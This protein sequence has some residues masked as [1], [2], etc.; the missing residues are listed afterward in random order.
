MGCNSCSNITLPGSAGASGT[1]GGEGIRGPQGLTGPQGPSVSVIEIDTDA[2]N[3]NTSAYPASGSPNKRVVIPANTWQ[4]IDDLVELEMMFQFRSKYGPSTAY[5]VIK[6]ELG[7]LPVRV[8][9]LN[10]NNELD[11]WNNVGRLGSDN[12]ILKVRLELPMTAIGSVMPILQT[13]LLKGTGTGNETHSLSA[14]QTQETYGRCDA[15]SGLTLSGPLDL[16]VYMKNYVAD[17]SS[18]NMVYYK[19]LSYKKIV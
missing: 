15:T 3:G 1:P 13:T 10:F 4:N 6:V 9:C 7:G 17:D 18:F 5:P 19:L 11:F 14:Q 8:S 2:H 12:N 16:D